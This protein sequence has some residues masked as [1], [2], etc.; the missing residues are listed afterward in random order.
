M[1]ISNIYVYFFVLSAQRA[2]SDSTTVAV[3]TPSAQILASKTI[4]ATT[5]PWR[6]G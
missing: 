3:S 6:N 4:K 5:S 2:F 1:Y